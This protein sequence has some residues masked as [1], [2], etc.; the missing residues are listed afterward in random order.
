MSTE[1]RSVGG[2]A[3]PS[4]LKQIVAQ[5]IRRQ[6][7]SGEMRPGTKVDQD[8]LAEQLGVSKLP[9]REA[10]IA[11]DGE[12]IIQTAPRR[13]AF[14]AELSREDIRDQYW[15]LGVISGLAAERAA[16]RLDDD[17]L[18]ALGKLAAQME[19]DES[20]SDHDRLNFD[21]HRLINRACGSRRLV[22][23]LK[24]LSSSIPN[25]FFEAH[26]DM[27]IS[28][29]RDH[30]EILDAMTTRSGG[31]AR[32]LTEAHFLRGGNHAVALLED[33]GFWN[34]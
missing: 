18:A 24:Q 16:A 8:A 20:S 17:H 12:G 23:E 2:A 13:G 32:T 34:R 19:A 4:V 14:V 29:N 6:V 27:V 10:L 1:M 9:V 7:F 21:F 28:S 30:H 3:T 22:A 11:L 31:M 33:R 15:L 26:P 25:G 5:E